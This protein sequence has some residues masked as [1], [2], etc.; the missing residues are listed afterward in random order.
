MRTLLACGILL[1]GSAAGQPIPDT[2]HPDGLPSAVETQ[3]HYLSGTG[4]GE[5]VDWRF[6]IS[7][8]RR[9]GSWS[10]LAVPSQWQL[11]GFGTYAYGWQD[12]KPRA[13]G[14]YRFDFTV[15]AT[16]GGRTIRLVFEGVMTDTRVLIDGRQV[17]PEHRGGFTRFSYDVTG[18]LTAGREAELTV[19]VREHSER[20]SINRAERDAD[21]WVF[22]G[23]YRPVYLEATP[24]SAIV[25]A[26]VDAR[27]DGTLRIEAGITG[28]DAS[29]GA[30]SGAKAATVEVE[31]REAR[32][33]RLVSRSA[34]SVAGPV[35]SFETSIDEVRPWSA[36]DPF[37][38]DLELSLL[39]SSG[40]LL[41]RVD[42]RIG[43]R[44]VDLV[45]GV[46]FVVNGHR[47]LLKGISR[48]S[49]YP[50]SG[51]TLNR[52][53]N[54]ADAELIKA[55]NVNAVRASHYPPD[56]EFLEACDRLGLY[57]L[58]ELPGWHDAYDFDDGAPLVAEMVARD[59]NHPS[60]IAWD[61]GNEGGWNDDLD[62]HF[63]RHDLQ[64][65]PV[66]H[67][68]SVFRGLD[69]E[70]YPNWQEL[71]ERLD[72]TTLSNR[73]KSLFGPLPAVL[74][75]EG[76]H[77]LYDGG[78]GAGL[79]AY[80]SLIRNS[81]RGAGFFLWTFLDEGVARDDRGGEIDTYSN[82][83]PDGIVGPYRE[84]EGSYWT[85][86]DIWSPVHF[87]RGPLGDGSGGRLLVENRYDMTDLD[88]LRFEV[89]WLRFPT[90]WQARGEEIVA[91]SSLAGPSVAPGKTGWIDLGPMP[92]GVDAV[93]VRAL[94]PEGREV[95]DRVLVVGNRRRAAPELRR[96]RRRAGRP[97]VV[98]DE[99]TIEL[100]S[101][102]LSAVLDRS[103][104]E[105]ITLGL[106]V[107]GRPRR[108]RPRRG[109]P[110]VGGVGSH[111]R[112]PT[113]RPGALE[114]RRRRSV[115]VGGCGRRFVSTGRRSRSPFLATRFRGL[116]DPRLS[117]SLA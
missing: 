18:L 100:R 70:H 41:H 88:R 67:P 35:W 44:S 93:R 8:G 29:S 87:G 57:V 47:V 11:E 14:T 58:D 107:V 95:A 108:G 84:K 19:H 105:L 33:G 32:S 17:G 89:E 112:S 30:S 51:R 1:A 83:A 7:E 97:T 61:N 15:P 20:P 54:A 2:R 74:V 53:I 78:H 46:G 27:H 37:L 102:R 38:Y 56:V 110:R 92:S 3:R 52:E 73:I 25:G 6:Q 81:E 91:R 50:D 101:G 90:P 9:S 86:R 22:G 43:F 64:G 115:E 80:W 12:D 4:R 48:H 23:I 77:G 104:G 13:E 65:R 113:G 85:V 111:R 76:L 66:L 28:F 39:D 71:S 24:Q 60:V 36:E 34:G 5:T 26:R 68:D 75:T 72:S 45:P 117:L 96:Q 59:H 116:A 62:D 114:G 98:E 31:L 106:D 103:T 94:E 99:R 21:Y 42:E 63:L 16:W 40:G 109:R 82:F 55:M 79:E 69:T 10:T 49:F